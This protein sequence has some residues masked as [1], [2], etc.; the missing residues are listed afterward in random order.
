MIVW[1][2]Q[3]GQSTDYNTNEQRLQKYIA[4]LSALLKQHRLAV[5]L[6]NSDSSPC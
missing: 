6:A 2:G 4:D 1:V 3:A 5:M